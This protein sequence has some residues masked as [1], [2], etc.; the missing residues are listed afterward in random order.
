MV[1]CTNTGTG[2][3]PTVRYLL[4]TGTC[5]G[6]V[7]YSTG[8]HTSAYGTGTVRYGTVR[9]GS[10]TVALSEFSFG[11]TTGLGTGTCKSALAGER[12]EGEKEADDD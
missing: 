8:Y 11:S 12:K 1:P 10:G 2:T 7:R 9:Y 3:V 6:T 4:R 5:T